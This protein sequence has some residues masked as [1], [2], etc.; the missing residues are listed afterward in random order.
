MGGVRHRARSL[1]ERNKCVKAPVKLQRRGELRTFHLHNKGRNK[2]T[3]ESCFNSF[4]ISIS[5]G[6]NYATPYQAKIDD[7]GLHNIQTELIRLDFA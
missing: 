6:L 3:S 2:Q 7:K 4:S 1:R 5:F